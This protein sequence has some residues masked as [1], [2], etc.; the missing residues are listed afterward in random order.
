MFQTTNQGCGC[1]CIYIY[2]LFY[3]IRTLPYTAVHL[4]LAITLYGNG[5][6]LLIQYMS[7]MQLN[8]G[9]TVKLSA[10][11]GIESAAKFAGKQQ[12]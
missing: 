9:R 5:K 2:I 1:L 6:K 10:P 4:G 12:T 11:E 7:S 3:V 8:Q